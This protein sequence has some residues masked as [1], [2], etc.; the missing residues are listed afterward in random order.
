[1]DR[2]LVGTPRRAAQPIL[3][4]G[5]SHVYLP[6]AVPGDA[7]THAQL[8]LEG[9]PEPMR[10]EPVLR[11]P[12][13]EHVWEAWQDRYAAAHNGFAEDMSLARALWLVE[14]VVEQW[15]R[16][17]KQGLPYL[18]RGQA[19]CPLPEPR[20]RKDP[21]PEAFPPPPTPALVCFGW[22]YPLRRE[23]REGARHER[24]EGPVVLDE[25]TYAT[26]TPLPVENWWR[27][28]THA[29][30]AA[31]D[32][33]APEEAWCRDGKTPPAVEAFRKRVGR[34]YRQVLYEDERL[35]IRW[36]AREDTFSFEM[37]FG[38]YC[39]EDADGLIYQFSGGSIELSASATMLSSFMHTMRKTLPR[40]RVR[41]DHAKGR[42]PFVS[43]TGALCDAGNFSRNIVASDL[44]P[45]AMIL[46]GL[47]DSIN[48]L[49][50]G[51]GNVRHSP[52]RALSSSG[53]PVISDKTRRRLGIPL[54]RW[55]H[56]ERG[57]EA[58]RI[59]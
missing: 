54:I 8:W 2:E 21:P 53:A 10:L 12:F 27:A 48:I 42:N 14:S 28:Y 49:M 57:K 37:P 50:T 41:G 17:T 43:E 4:Y 3:I 20:L 7:D 55:Q 32:A 39:L 5:H 35:K 52:F 19:R 38:P 51:G 25:R 34:A 24:H 40:V 29:V 26:T 46:R 59:G 16:S 56:E 23:S 31:L 1:M 15:E 6:M 9:V 45:G 33:C 18:R 36:S 11:A 13:Q 44:S 47:R 58:I 22:V 30:Q